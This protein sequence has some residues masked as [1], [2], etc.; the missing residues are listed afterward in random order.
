MISRA[1]PDAL[2]R[3]RRGGIQNVSL[4]SAAPSSGPRGAWPLCPSVPG[5][6]PCPGV[7]SLE[8]RRGQ[9]RHTGRCGSARSVASRS[10]IPTPAGAL[11]THAST[12]YTRGGQNCDAA[13]PT[14]QFGSPLWRRARSCQSGCRPHDIEDS[15]A[16][17][18]RMA[19]HASIT[20]SGA[21]HK[22]VRRLL[23]LGRD[24]ARCVPTPERCL[25]SGPRQPDD[26]ERSKT[27]RRLRRGSL[28]GPPGRGLWAALMRWEGCASRWCARRT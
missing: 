8:P 21:Q 2:E 5:P 3:P 16:T 6:P 20:T 13:L 4:Q 24:S 18:S 15:G 7:Y 28:A 11:C 22:R 25:G 12:R 26:C 9:G 23:C 1:Y 17:R 10:A 19:Q 14:A 27:S